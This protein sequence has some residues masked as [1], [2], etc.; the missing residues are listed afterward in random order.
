MKGLIVLRRLRCRGKMTMQVICQFDAAANV[1]SQV[2][3]GGTCGRTLPHGK[4][5]V[6]AL[7]NTL[8][9]SYYFR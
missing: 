8:A 6:V 3:V 5:A 9:V 1:V 7:R 4:N 2:S